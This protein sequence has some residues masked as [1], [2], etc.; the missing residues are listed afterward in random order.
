MIFLAGVALFYPLTYLKTFS[1]IRNILSYRN[2]AY[3]VRDGLYYKH[4][5][6]GQFNIKAHMFRSKLWV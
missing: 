3:A 2:E 6:T 4:W 1:Y 5:K